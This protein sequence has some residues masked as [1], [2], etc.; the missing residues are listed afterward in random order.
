MISK[1]KKGFKDWSGS[2]QDPK[3]LKDIWDA[4]GA[5][6]NNYTP[7]VEQGLASL[8]HRMSQDAVS[9]S[10]IVSLRPALRFWKIAAAM[11]ILLGGAYVF[12]RAWSAENMES[13]A[14]EAGTRKSISLSDHSLI[15]LNQSSRLTYPEIFG[16]NKRLVSLEGEAFFE[17]ERDE[18]RPFLVETALADVEVL[19]TSFNIRSYPDQEEVEVF[20]K[21]GQVRVS[22][23]NNGASYNLLPGD[24]LVYQKSAT[25]ANLSRDEAG[26]ALFWKEGLASFREKT[27][28]EIFQGLE[29]LYGVEI[30]VKNKSML[31]C[32][33]TLTAESGK[34][35]EAFEAIRT[36]CPVII[37]KT[38]AGKYAVSGKCCD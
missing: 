28:R 27:F 25:G 36:A 16:K 32:K 7:D 11:L 3:S 14:A 30:G 18:N 37:E 4:T 8:K 34:L 19:G 6:N 9:K 1:E 10:R 31:D 38:T 23:K 33:F 29:Q 5:F 12:Q 24:K 21:T 22:I 17:I 20:V 35:H 2:G 13:L 15:T 26:I